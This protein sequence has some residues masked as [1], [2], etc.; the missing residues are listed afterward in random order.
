LELVHCLVLGLV[1][2]ID[3]RT[4]LHRNIVFCD[5]LSFYLVDVFVE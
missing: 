4:L 2:R 3:R 5:F 1:G